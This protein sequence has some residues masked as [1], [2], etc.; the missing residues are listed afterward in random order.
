MKVHA[1]LL[2]SLL[3][4]SIS[5]CGSKSSSPSA[6]SLEK[7]LKK[8]KSLAS[9]GPVEIN[10]GYL[11]VLSRANPNVA[12]QLKNPA[13]KK[14]LVDNL[15]EQE[16]LYRESVNRGIPNKPEVQEKA[17]LYER[18][19]FA[20]AVLDDAVDKKAKEY[21]DQ[22][23]DKEF[24]RVK[25]AQI[26]IKTTPPPPKPGQKPETKVDNKALEE[27]AL[28]KAQ[29]A[30][31]K[32]DAGAAWDA[33]V[34]EYSEDISSKNRGGELGLLSRNDRRAE[35]LGWNEMIEKVFTMQV[36]QV[37]DPILAKDGYHVVKILEATQIAPYEEVQNT[38]KFK[39]RSQVKNELMTKLTGGKPTEYKDESL[40]AASNPPAVTLPGMPPQ[41]M[42]SGPGPRITPERGP[43]PP[44]PGKGPVPVQIPIK[45]PSN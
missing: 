1:V 2:C 37:S 8:G 18:V 36:G 32:L 35:R 9:L 27:A 30:K 13:G 15:L 4:F 11:E 10:E 5:A 45:K 33:V 42:P 43:V 12:A 23:K 14:R 16:L 39:L 7:D 44:I 17:A 28:K 25:V 38:I 3:T 20:Q 34:T 21:Y 40:K 29:E 24:A 22:N 26:L 6:A 19:I 41:T 31:S